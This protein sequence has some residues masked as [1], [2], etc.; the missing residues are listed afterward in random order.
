EVPVNSLTDYVQQTFA[1][2]G[3]YIEFTFQDAT[4]TCIKGVRATVAFHKAAS[5]TDTGTTNIISGATTTAVYSGDHLGVALNW[6]SS[7]VTPG[8]APWDQAEVNALVGRIGYG[9]D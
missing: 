4:Q 7:M 5:Q 6:K 2:S 8:A 1:N 3:T 9:T